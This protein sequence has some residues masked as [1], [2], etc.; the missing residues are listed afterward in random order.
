[1]DGLLDPDGDSPGLAGGVRELHAHQ[2]LHESKVLVCVLDNGLRG[3]ACGNAE[4]ECAVLNVDL[5]FF[6]R[7]GQRPR[8]VP[9]SWSFQTPEA[10]SVQYPQWRT[11]ENRRREGG[12]ELCLITCVFKR[13][14]LM[15]RDY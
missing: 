12:G 1:M 2:A 13:P 11:G 5:V 14:A 7:E 15:P 6:A 9:K 10:G 3:Q 8:F 4:A